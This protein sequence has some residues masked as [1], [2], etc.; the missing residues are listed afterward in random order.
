VRGQ[1]LLAAV[2]RDAGM[3]SLLSGFLFSK[4]YHAVS[5]YRIAH[6]LYL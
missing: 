4:G 6:V 1:D 3:P 2:M 5:T